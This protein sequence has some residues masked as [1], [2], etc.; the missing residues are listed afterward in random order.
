MKLLEDRILR[1]GVIVDGGILKVDMF[2]NH[3]LDI[4]LLDKLGEEF[5]RIFKGHPVD[6][7]LTIEASGIAIAAL[8]AR[9]FGVPAV[10]AKK[11][12]PV[13]MRDDALHTSVYS[14]TKQKSYE[15]YVQR[16]FLTPGEHILIIDDFLAHGNAAEGL[17]DLAEAA[18]A[19]VSGVG[20]AIEKHFQGGRE[21]L[22]ARGI[23][24]QSLAEIEKIENGQVIFLHQP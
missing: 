17:C 7:I 11:A 1:D 13:T 12:K 23:L 19:L 2:L 24:V 22:Q 5:Y 15:V 3:R 4:P 18:G 21:R 6:K 14:F 16:S 8:T 9:H 10:F 20:I